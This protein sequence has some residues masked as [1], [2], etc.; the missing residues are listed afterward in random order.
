MSGL[1]IIIMA[2]AT[3]TTP[4]G[5]FPRRFLLSAAAPVSTGAAAVQPSGTAHRSRPP[6][7]H[8]SGIIAPS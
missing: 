3:F 7:T 4:P 6:V 8:R 1:R 5:A 2:A